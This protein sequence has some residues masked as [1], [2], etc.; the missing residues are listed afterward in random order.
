MSG[1]GD[2]WNLAAQKWN[3]T[4]AHVGDD[5]WDT[6]TTCDGWTVR[7]LVDHAMH[8]QG[9]GGGALGAGTTPGQDWAEVQPAMAAALQDPANFEGTVEQFGGMPR[10]AARAACD[11]AAR[12]A[13]SVMTAASARRNS[14]GP[15]L[16]S[17]GSQMAAAFCAACFI[18]ASSA[19]VLIRQAAASLASSGVSAKLVSAISAAVI[20]PPLRQRTTA[21]AAVA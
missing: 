5:D 10:Q 7:D 2:I 13:R 4:I 6:A 9:L 20:F 15:R 1:P 17:A 11:S 14:G 18:T 21:A 19:S 8:W 16:S 12:M 3:D